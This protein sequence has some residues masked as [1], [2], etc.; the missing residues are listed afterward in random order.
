MRG[1]ALPVRRAADGSGSTVAPRAAAKRRD[2]A[3][4]VTFSDVDWQI[5]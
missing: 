5:G 4:D 3:A 1:S 2:G